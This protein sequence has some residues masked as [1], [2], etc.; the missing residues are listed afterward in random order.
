METSFLPED[1]LSGIV[2]GC[3]DGLKLPLERE[4]KE[5]HQFYVYTKLFYHYLNFSRQ[6]P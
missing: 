3:R 1:N 4:E 6:C 2:K 5:K